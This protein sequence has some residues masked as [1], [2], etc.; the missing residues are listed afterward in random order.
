MNTQRLIAALAIAFAGSAAYAAEYTN[1]DI[2]AGST[3]SRADAA[4][5][6][7]AGQVSKVLG[8]EVRYYGDAAVFDVP[9][10]TGARERSEFA[11][12]N[13]GRTVIFNEATTFID[14]APSDERVAQVL[15][16]RIK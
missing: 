3:L 12:R 16:R 1:F 10:P 2:P 8:R 7:R 5:N 13:L 4:T 15:G 11:S 9:A 14:N 6:A